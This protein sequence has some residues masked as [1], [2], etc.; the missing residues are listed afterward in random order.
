[1]PYVETP[2]QQSVQRTHSHVVKMKVSS[3]MGTLSGARIVILSLSLSSIVTLS[4]EDALDFG[5]VP[6]SVD[7]SLTFSP[8]CD[9]LDVT[10]VFSEAP[11]PMEVPAADLDVI[12]A[13]LD[14][15]LAEP[16]VPLL[17]LPLAS[18]PATLL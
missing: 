18:A 16:E 11:P 15:W 10:E 7:D 1:M 8:L 6:A 3:Q 13:D 2:Q 12:F 14:V 9:P 17:V 4:P 5:V